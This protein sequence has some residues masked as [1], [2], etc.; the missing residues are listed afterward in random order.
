MN[1]LVTGAIRGIG[2]AIAANLIKE[3]HKVFVSARNEDLL[4]HYEI[5]KMSNGKLANDF[6]NRRND[7]SHGNGTLDFTN[8]EVICYE[9]LRICIYCITLKRAGFNDEEIEKIVKRIFN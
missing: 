2:N 9:L 5:E 4:K 3:R 8:E 6:V 7:I 1:I